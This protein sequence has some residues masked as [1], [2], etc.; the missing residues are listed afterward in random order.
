VQLLETIPGV[1]ALT[2]LQT[3]AE[4]GEIERFERAA[5]LVSYAG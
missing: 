1:G 3:Y 2:A 4:I 5:E